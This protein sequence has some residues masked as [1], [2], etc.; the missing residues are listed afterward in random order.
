MTVDKPVS[1]PQRQFASQIRCIRYRRFRRCVGRLASW[2][3]DR[4][5]WRLRRTG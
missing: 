3:R 1:E 2:P 4:S 5:E